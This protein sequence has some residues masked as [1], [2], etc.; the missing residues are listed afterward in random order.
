MHVSSLLGVVMVLVAATAAS[1]SGSPESK[2]PAAAKSTAAK[3]SAAPLCTSFTI[4]EPV[5]RVFTFTIPKNPGATFPLTASVE[6]QK[7][8]ISCARGD[9]GADCRAGQNPQDPVVVKLDLASTD[10][11]G[12]GQI[13]AGFS[14]GDF[15]I[16]KGGWT[17]KCS[18]AP[19][20][21]SAPPKSK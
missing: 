20:K 12:M 8:T 16:G 7:G 3:T 18:A 13:L 6:S 10:P 17:L 11:D 14:A 2:S 15:S 21:S 1:A 19:K 9:G 4:K 5:P